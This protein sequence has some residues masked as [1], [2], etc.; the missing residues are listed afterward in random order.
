MFIYYEE[1]NKMNHKYTYRG[2]YKWIPNEWEYAK[3]IK[4]QDKILHL[5]P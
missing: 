1:F 2:I 4:G 3:F 5:C